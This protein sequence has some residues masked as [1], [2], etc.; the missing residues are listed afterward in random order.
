MIISHIILLYGVNPSTTLVSSKDVDVW[1]LKYNRRWGTSLLVKLS[2][3][4][5]SVKIDRVSLASIQYSID[6]SSSQSVDIVWCVSKRMSVSWLKERCF[7]STWF[8][9]SVVK[10]DW[11][12]DIGERSVKSSSDKNTTVIKANSNRVR[13][14]DKILRDLFSV[15]AVLVEVVDHYE[16]LVVTVSKE[17]YLRAGPQLVVE[18]LVCVPIWELN[19]GVL[20]VTNTLKHLVNNCINIKVSQLTLRVET[21]CAMFEL[22]ERRII[23]TIDLHKLLLKSLQ[24]GF[25][26]S[27]SLD[28]SLQFLVEFL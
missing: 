26:L 11:A 21:N 7:L 17:D 13:L 28:Q 16:V 2:Y 22:I 10:K 15:P 8:I 25:V 27:P 12:R 3:L 24:F 14:K 20:Q 9:F 18:E 5:P 23:L 4:L 1:I 19:Q 6:R